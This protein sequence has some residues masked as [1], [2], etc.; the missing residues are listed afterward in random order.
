MARMGEEE[1]KLEQDTLCLLDEGVMGGVGGALKDCWAGRPK[2]L[3]GR[4]WLGAF[5]GGNYLS[6][7]YIHM[8]WLALMRR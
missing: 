3:G 8:C 2:V 6:K 4:G 5:A 7:Q 1:L